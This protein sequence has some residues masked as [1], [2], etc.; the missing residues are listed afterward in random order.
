VALNGDLKEGPVVGSGPWVWDGSRG[1]TGYFFTD[2]PRY[3]EDALPGVARLNIQIVADQQTRITAFRVGR[4][5]LME[6]PAP[7]VAEL[8]E[9]YPEIGYLQYREPG[10]GLEIAL[11]S[12][13]PPLDNLQVRKALFN[14]LDP[15]DAID[16]VWGGAGFVS[17]G[18]P[19]ADPGWLLPEEEFRD[20]L[21]DP[22]SSR[23]LFS[24][25]PGELPL[26]FTL[27]V[28]DYGDTH[29]EYGQRIAER[30]E[31]VG[32]TVSVK[33]V[34]PTDYP[35]EVWY[36]GSYDAFV[37]PIAPMTTPNMY[38]LTVLHS[39]GAWNT[40]SYRDPDLDSLIE[41]QATSL[42]PSHRQDLVLDI[43]RH[44]MDKAVRFMPVTKVSSWVWLPQVKGFNPN[45]AS[46]EYFYLARL[47]VEE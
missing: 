26:S 13:V 21:A 2:N 6:A 43:Q 34:N 36:G 5:D 24:S 11:K 7:Q 33:T 27:T 35:Q 23:D 46:S 10:S 47:D 42:D 25:A 37:G 28:A 20:Y 17:Q 4:I 18:M 44:V 19:V 32:F 39:R 12:L 45:L 3:Y 1:D 16:T 9:A 31:A 41:E 22:D 8:R 38:L 30:L 14:A 29:L 15:W 40:H